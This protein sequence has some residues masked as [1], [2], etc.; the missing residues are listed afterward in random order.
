VHG[1]VT[2]DAN[3]IADA[4]ALDRL[5]FRMLQRF[6]PI[7]AADPP[8][9]IVIDSAGADHLHGGE[10]AML[11]ILVEKLASVGLCREP[12]WPENLVR[13]FSMS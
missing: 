7:V 13:I 4:E 1:L 6:A 5:A 9:G 3:P 8:A 10:G 11:A 12:S 2:Q